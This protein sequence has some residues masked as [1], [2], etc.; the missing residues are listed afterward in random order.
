MN[1][2][3]PT[4]RYCAQPLDELG[5]PQ[6]ACR[7]YQSGI[8]II[9]GDQ[10]GPTHHERLEEL[11]AYD[12]LCAQV[13]R[14]LLEQYAAGGVVSGFSRVLDC[15]GD[16]IYYTWRHN[17]H[18]TMIALVLGQEWISR[19]PF[20]SPGGAPG[21]FAD[22]GLI[23]TREIFCQVIWNTIEDVALGGCFLNPA[24]PRSFLRWIDPVGERT[25]VVLPDI[26]DAAG[27][28]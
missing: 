4:C 25:V 24:E 1:L 15:V 14:S 23:D 16:A 20:S 13:V 22:A 5:E 2:R 27:R 17:P 10:N 12:D 26:Y 7:S 18:R 8:S 3:L 19:F 21:D 11:I 6:R 9:T 28:T